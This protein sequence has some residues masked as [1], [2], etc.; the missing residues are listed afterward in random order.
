MTY[1]GGAAAAGA[2]VATA[3]A[4]ALKANGGIVKMNPE[5]FKKILNKTEAPL[6]VMA[7]GGVFKTNYQYLINYKGIFFFTKA[8]EPLYLPS[9]AE[10]VNSKSIWIPG[11]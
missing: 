4:N 6:V 2:A 8:A 10:I 1:G 5:E 3:I 7:E 9:D 11:Q